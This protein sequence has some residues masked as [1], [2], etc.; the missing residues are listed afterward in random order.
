MELEVTHL[1]RSRDYPKKSKNE[2]D[3]LDEITR[4]SI[5]TNL[6]KILQPIARHYLLQEYTA[7]RPRDICLINFNC[8]VEENDKWYVKFYQHKVNR[9]QQL[10]AT[11]EIRQLIE[12][13]QQWIQETL[14]RD[15]PYL[16]CHFRNIKKVAYP[17]F[18]DIKPLP[19]PPLVDSFENPM[20]RIIRML[21]EKEH[22]LDANGQKPHF[23]GKITLRS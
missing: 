22:I 5:K 18:P 16:F 23:T 3:W 10:P 19:K 13:Q 4:T 12:K 1:I 15:Y 17:Q 14:G 21:I 9:W 6:S 7:A 2:P 8:L 20:V 11:R